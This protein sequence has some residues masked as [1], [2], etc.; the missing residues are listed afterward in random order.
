MRLPAFLVDNDGDIDVLGHRIGLYSIV[1]AHQEGSS[2]VEIHDE[3]PTLS[4]D[5]VNQVVAFYMANRDVVDAYV[6]AYQA[7]L[8]HLEEEALRKTQD[9]TRANRLRL[10]HPRESGVA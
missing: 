7:D 2:I 1:K 5:L 8:V 6:A 10:R 9:S 4:L 3:F